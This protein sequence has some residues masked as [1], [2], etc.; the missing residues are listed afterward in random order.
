ME[1]PSQL[2]N[3]IKNKTMNL[4]TI[5]NDFITAQAKF[6][7]KAYADCFSETAIVFDEAERTKGKRK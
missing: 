4:P 5:I 3:N 2:F 1:E 7:S 6:D